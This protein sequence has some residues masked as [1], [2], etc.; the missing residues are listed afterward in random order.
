MHIYIL[1]RYST[2]HKAYSITDIMYNLINKLVIK[3]VLSTFLCFV[4][5]IISYFYLVIYLLKRFFLNT[6]C[7]LDIVLEVEM[8]NR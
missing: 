6:T 4:I 8:P 2:Y 5:I 7:V 1:C 3:C